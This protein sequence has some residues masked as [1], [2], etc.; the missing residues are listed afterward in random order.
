[1]PIIVQGNHHFNPTIEPVV[2]TDHYVI[3]DGLWDILESAG[4]SAV[5]HSDGTTVAAGRGISQTSAN[6]WKLYVNPGGTLWVRAQRGATA[7]QW[8]TF[9]DT[10]LPTGGTA[11]TM[12]SHADSVQIQGIIGNF[13][14]IAAD[15]TT[16]RAHLW[17]NVEATPN[18][19]VPFYFLLMNRGSTTNL[20][21]FG[22][23]T[24][25]QVADGVVG[26]QDTQDYVIWSTSGSTSNLTR[27]GSINKWRIWYRRGLSGA[28][29][30]T[31]SGAS[32]GQTGANGTQLF[33]NGIDQV[34]SYTGRY[35]KARCWIG[36]STAGRFQ[37]PKGRGRFFRFP[38]PSTS[39]IG[40]YQ[41]LDPT[42]TEAYLRLADFLLP[43]PQNTASPV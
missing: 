3:Y 37:A 8:R 22:V 29:L 30:D 33:P 43:W 42:T 35:R 14:T 2:S 32:W 39:V 9:V 23:E 36:S 26:D 4:W 41:R 15:A 17:A 19:F 24:L 27:T 1:M 13:T 21:A 12:P 7:A 20:D 28:V 38:G 25:D 40:H 5:E 18:S 34:D 6:A 10:T 11:S 31:G 16:I